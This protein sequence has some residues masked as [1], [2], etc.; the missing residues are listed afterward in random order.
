MLDES[1]PQYR[2]QAPVLSLA[3]DIADGR[4]QAA[5][6]LMAYRDL[7]MDVHA[8]VEAAM[9]RLKLNSSEL[10]SQLLLASQRIVATAPEMLLPKAGMLL[11]TLPAQSD[12]ADRVCSFRF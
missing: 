9:G 8:D 4:V 2:Q 12:A 7:R 10:E 1:D 5:R 6:Q 3:Q 11:R